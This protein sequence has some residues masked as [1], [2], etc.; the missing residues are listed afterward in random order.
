MRMWVVCF[1]GPSLLFGS[2]GTDALFF[3]FILSNK[4]K[5]VCVLSF[6]SYALSRREGGRGE[7]MGDGMPFWR[8]PP[9]YR[10]ALG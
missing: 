1:Y 9:G 8:G 7:A 3:L 2:L 6:I 5:E 10:V 4:S